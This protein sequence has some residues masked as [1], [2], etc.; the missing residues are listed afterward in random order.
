MS[1][2]A[3]ASSRRKKA[4]IEPPVLSES[5]Y[6]KL[7]EFRYLLRRFLVFSE[8]AAMRAGLTA[9]QHQA[10]LAIKGFGRGRGVSTGTLADRLGIRHHS[11]V[12]LV[13]RLVANGLALRRSGTED[14]RQVLVLL[15][16]EAETCL[17]RLSLVHR[18]ELERL[19]P[20]LQTLLR[21]FKV[22]WD[23]PE[24]EKR[25]KPVRKAD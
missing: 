19:A 13:D 5:D 16:L 24:G 8:A 21:Y 22:D 25:R 4:Q 3:P 15:T 18:R 7:A 9:Q 12:G 10:L 11:A 20:A 1:P 23:R 14:R 6:A 17:R 2:S